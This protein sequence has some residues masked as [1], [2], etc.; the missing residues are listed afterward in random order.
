MLTDGLNFMI[1][2]FKNNNIVNNISYFTT[3]EEA[4]DELKELKKFER[5]KIINESS[6]FYEIENSEGDKILYQ[7]IDRRKEPKWK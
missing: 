6:D 4:Y 1:V 2:R 7:I 5:N 3:F